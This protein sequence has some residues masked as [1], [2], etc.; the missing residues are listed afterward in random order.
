M[1]FAPSALKLAPGFT[2]NPKTF[3]GYRVDKARKRARDF[4]ATCPANSNPTTTAQPSVLLKLTAPMKHLRF[5]NPGPFGYLLVTDASGTTHCVGKKRMDLKILPAGALQ[6]RGAHAPMHRDYAR[7]GITFS[8]LRFT[9]EDLSRKGK[10]WWRADTPT[11]ALD[12]TLAKPKIIALPPSSKRSMKRCR[13]NYAYSA[14]P[15]II[16]DVKRP[17]RKRNYW[18][19]SGARAEIYLDGPY[20][21]DHRPDDAEYGEFCG[22]GN[23][24][25]AQ[26]LPDLELGRYF[27]YIGYVEPDQA[28][29]AKLILTDTS[30]PLDRFAQ[31][32]KVSLKRP[33]HERSL[34]D[35][36]PFLFPYDR[37][38]ESLTRDELQS[39]WQKAPV[40]MRVYPK[41]DLDASSALAPRR[42]F[43]KRKG[44]TLAF[45]KKDEALLWVREGYVVAADGATF[46]VQKPKYLTDR[47]PAALVVPT[48]VRNFFIRDLKEAL[49]MTGPSDQK[50]VKS[51]T[52]A[53]AKH[54][55]CRQK[56]W[57][58]LYPSG[59]GRLKKVTYRGG[60]IVKVQD[61]RTSV[62]KKA[63]RKCRTPKFRKRQDRLLKTLRTSIQNRIQTRLTTLAG[64]S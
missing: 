29:P 55:T 59:S 5:R 48:T 49:S 9:V 37:E 60:R 43:L 14:Q 33:F 36:Y 45:P 39:L 31:I 15:S 56:V 63:D 61:W 12:G 51:Y 26:R 50:K 1:K 7:D 25:T 40:S 35:I 10:T 23:R 16:F 21:E 57:D 28:E 4:G 30:T 64:T 3:A 22:R 20:T 41:F 32:G 24:S 13:S 2:P 6:V 44:V 8:K 47:Q 17:I 53:L 54:D 38:L 11:V 19:V 18:L 46:K 52:K 34:L 62:S 27:V 58:K 42:R